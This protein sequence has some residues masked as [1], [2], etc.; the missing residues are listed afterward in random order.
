MVT[1]I[2]VRRQIS[3][4]HSE[5]QTAPG[6]TA[7]L[8]QVGRSVSVGEL[9]PE[10]LAVAKHCLLDWLGVTLA[11]S[12]EPLSEI[13]A[14]ELGTGESREATLIGRPGRASAHTAALVNGAAGHALDF[15]DMHLTVMGHPSVAVAPGALALSERLEASGA[16]LLTGFVAGVEV[17][18]RLGALVG[19]SHYE[20]GWHNTATLGTFGAAGACARLL[21]LDE[22]RWLHALGI[23]GTQAAGLKGVFGTMSKPLHAGRAAAN[24]LLAAGL[25]ARGFTS[26]REI[27]EGSQGFGSTHTDALAGVEILEPLTG[28][29]L[30]R[31]TLF[32]YHAA[33]YFTHS[34]IESALT[35]RHADGVRREDVE[36][37]EVEVSPDAL[38]VANIGEPRTGLEGK[39]SL[40]AVTAMALLGDDMSDPGAYCDER[41]AA[42]EL[43][44]LR[45]RIRV[46]PGGTSPTAGSVRV[47]TV[48]GRALTASADT[49]IPAADLAGQGERLRA[50]FMALAGPVVGQ[51]RAEAIP[52]IIA[53][54]DE[55]ERVSDLT[56][57]LSAP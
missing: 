25:A 39:F 6:A 5:P 1:R 42:P 17:E 33:C 41:M 56:R 9:P 45:D 2:A 13:L 49:S 8:A 44:A 55:L 37:V 26:S 15:D 47:R 40:R 30:I 27:V 23:A 57:L 18:C 20:R 36:A 46:V 38:D 3:I 50:K 21:G 19:P 32:K 7:A 29:Y 54:L 16:E 48:D 4:P 11:G 14:V 53:R 35:I 24:G 51:E 31:D 22:E 28:R 34:I 43:V 10:A 52:A 12:R